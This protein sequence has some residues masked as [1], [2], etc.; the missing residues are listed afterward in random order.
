MN[1]DST[2]GRVLKKGFSITIGIKPKVS[3]WIK[4][5]RELGRKKKLNPVN[6]DSETGI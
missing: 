1:E 3:N 4:L 5:K 6:N 2:L